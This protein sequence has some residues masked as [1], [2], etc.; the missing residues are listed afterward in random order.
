MLRSF[1]TRPSFC[2]VTYDALGWHITTIDSNVSLLLSEA[3][4]MQV[5]KMLQRC[6]IVPPNLP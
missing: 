2:V 5:I 4:A 3:R 6:N 1:L